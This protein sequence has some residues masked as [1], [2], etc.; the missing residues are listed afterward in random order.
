MES[1]PISNIFTS[2]HKQ[3]FPNRSNIFLNPPNEFLNL[4]CL[5]AEGNRR[6]NLQELMDIHRNTP[7]K[8]EDV[9]VDK[10]YYS[11][12]KE[13]NFKNNL[14][15]STTQPLLPCPEESPIS[16]RDRR[17]AFGL[18]NGYY[19]RFALGGIPSRDTSPIP[20]SYQ[21]NIDTP[22]Y[23]DRTPKHGI[24][25]TPLLRGNDLH[26]EGHTDQFNLFENPFVN[27][28]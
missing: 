7:N 2:A 19:D 21:R 11:E 12:K 5:S 10:F 14:T 13:N 17:K 18:E 9:E 16:H 27:K 24:H 23:R 8:I 26:D 28:F 20:A 22:S 1:F 3:T 15:N 6:L 25:F 4:N